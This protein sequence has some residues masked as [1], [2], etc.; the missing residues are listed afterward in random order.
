[1]LNLFQCYKKT[2][3][4]FL[5]LIFSFLQACSV[6]PSIFDNKFTEKEIK[7]STKISE[8][9]YNKIIV[10]KGETLFSISKKFNVS[11]DK[12]IL[13][14]ELNQK[15]FIFEGQ[16]LNIPTSNI[17]KNDLSGTNSF[18]KISLPVQKPKSVFSISQSIKLSFSLPVNGNI[19]N[20]F[21]LNSDGVVNEGINIKANL[22]EIVRASADGEVIFVGTNL[23]D[24]GTMLLIKHSNDLVTS[25]AHLSKTLVKEGE[26]IIQGQQI[27]VVGSTGKVT[28]TQLYFELR[29]DNEPLNP[30]FYFTS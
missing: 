24:F 1:M 23:K 21:G 17:K 25:Y 27:G 30:E 13:A 9:Q 26:F 22:G 15:N 12:I 2:S 3:Y 16:I 4:L 19:I 29:K 7:S 20:K 11:I 6:N 28:N 8:V 10:K 18:T 14:N 5:L